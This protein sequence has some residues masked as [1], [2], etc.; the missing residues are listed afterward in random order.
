MTITTHQ[1]KIIRSKPAKYL[2]SADTEIQDIALQELKKT[3]KRYARA[4]AMMGAVDGMEAD[5]GNA[6]SGAKW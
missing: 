5:W 3:P 1:K 4:M 6:P 2:N